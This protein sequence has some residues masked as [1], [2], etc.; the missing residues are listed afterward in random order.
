MASEDQTESAVPPFRPAQQRTE[1]SSSSSSRTIDGPTR[2]AQQG[3][4]HLHA[5]LAQHDEL[6]L[7]DHRACV[8]AAPRESIVRVLGVMGVEVQ[9]WKPKTNK[10]GDEMV[11]VHFVVAH[12]VSFSSASL[13]LA[14]I[15][16]TRCP[17]QQKGGVRLAQGPPLCSVASENT[18]KCLYELTLLNSSLFFH[19]CMCAS[20]CQHA[21]AD[22]HTP[23]GLLPFKQ[24]LT[25]LF[26]P[27]PASSRQTNRQTAG[28]A[29]R[30]QP[31]L[32]TKGPDQSR[33]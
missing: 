29:G 6:E 13:F 11:V 16:Q 30:H 23:V 14:Q 33:L 2:P 21:R 19:L 27:A 24:Q 4:S 28:V 22:P 20:F 31:N 15:H 8:L 12:L 1:S 7:K 9:G 17:A 25:S 32:L 10:H 3:T 5:A 18:P 26:T